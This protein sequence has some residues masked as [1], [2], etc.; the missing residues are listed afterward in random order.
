MNILIKLD[1]SCKISFDTLFYPNI[2]TFILSKHNYFIFF[3]KY[4]NHVSFH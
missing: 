1:K 4:L 2:K 3:K